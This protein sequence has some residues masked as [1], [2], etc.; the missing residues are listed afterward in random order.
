MPE[1][2][3]CVLYTDQDF[4]ASLETRGASWF[5]SD[6]Y[7]QDIIFYNIFI[8]N[9]LYGRVII[10]DTY[11]K[12]K[13][14]DYALLEW[15]GGYVSTFWPNLPGTIITRLPNLK[16]WCRL[17]YCRKAPGL[18][19][20]TGS[21]HRRNGNGTTGISVYPSQTQIPASTLK[22]RYVLAPA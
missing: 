18:R 10:E 20:M 14:G 6:I 22:T 4:A 16:K 15:F 5:R 17:S 8:H 19:N 12:L 11:R 7:R 9:N 1:D 21:S 2:E 3:R 13:D